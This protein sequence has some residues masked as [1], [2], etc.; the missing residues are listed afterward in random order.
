MSRMLDALRRIEAKTAALAEQPD[1]QTSA[2]PS[3]TPGASGREHSDQPL[4]SV[5]E[6]QSVEATHRAEA[7]LDR[8]ARSLA[9]LQAE[10]RQT[11]LAQLT[12]A[13]T[14][15]TPGEIQLSQ[16]EHNQTEDHQAEDG[17]PES[18]RAEQGQAEQQRRAGPLAAD[19]V[20]QDEPA[21]SETPSTQAPPLQS[22][23]TRPGPVDARL[24][25]SLPEA[26]T[27]EPASRAAQN[28]RQPALDQTRAAVETP[29]SDMFGPL[30]QACG[31]LAERILAGLP[32]PGTGSVLL[33][34]AACSEARVELLVGL[35]PAL[36]RSAGTELVVVDADFRR[37]E[38]TAR[39]GVLA[40]RGTAGAIAEVL[41]LGAS[42][43]RSATP[44]PAGRGRWGQLAR[45]ARSPGRVVLRFDLPARHFGAHGLWPGSAGCRSLAPPGSAS[46]RVYC[47]GPVGREGDWLKVQPARP[48]FSAGIRRFLPGYVEPMR[49]GSR[50]LKAQAARRTV[51]APDSTVRLR[52]PKCH[53]WPRHNPC[54]WPCAGK[55]RRQS[56]ALDRIDDRAADAR[57]TATAGRRLP[58]PG[59]KAAGR[60]FFPEC[61]QDPAHPRRSPQR[62]RAGLKAGYCVGPGT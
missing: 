23:E 7:T 46:V 49:R 24:H 58:A 43:G 10:E 12:P 45:C 60:E 18:S 37:A 20:G 14:Q 33:V 54:A 8:V 2:P 13:E 27:T 4:R 36:A 61:R 22:P 15:D 35:L 17:P 48:M 47:R 42:A 31:E 34:D 44:V 9:H 62:G 19:V 16:A 1:A 3:S 41:S 51:S 28:V 39:L 32:V 56:I 25:A 5:P 59:P 29:A 50:R 53:W 57:W 26:R 40:V 21:E 6:S 52:R 11:E 30:Q 55:K 38:L